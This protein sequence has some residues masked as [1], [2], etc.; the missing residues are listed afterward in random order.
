M[1]LMQKTQGTVASLY[2]MLIHT[3][4]NKK[5]VPITIKALKP[6]LVNGQHV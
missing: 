6:T 5:I 4:S 1:E 2:E 3:K